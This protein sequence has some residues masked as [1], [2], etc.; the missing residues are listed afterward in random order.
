MTS[1]AVAVA[2]GANVADDGRNV[3]CHIS[4]T[5]VPRRDA[6]AM[7]TTIAFQKT[8]TSSGCS[9]NQGY[10]TFPVTARGI[11]LFSDYARGGLRPEAS[12]FRGAYANC[13]FASKKEKE[14][15][16]SDGHEL[17]SGQEQ[18]ERVCLRSSKEAGSL[19]EHGRAD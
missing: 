18:V 12:I 8:A 14:R 6:S 5:A 11:R 1:G 10:D 4:A 16:I 13:R 3:L 15:V 2:Q 19:H 9:E 17:D 7:R